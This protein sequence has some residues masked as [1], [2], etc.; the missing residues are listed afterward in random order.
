MDDTH[1]TN[2]YNFSLITVLVV[3]LVKATL[4]HGDYVTELTNTFFFWQSETE[5]VQ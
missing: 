3:D 5:W 2:S 1:G 4:L